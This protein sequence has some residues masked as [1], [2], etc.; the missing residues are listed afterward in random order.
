M[1]ERSY[2]AQQFVD[3]QIGHAMARA[4][5]R[6]DHPIRRQLDMEAEI[7]GTRDVVVRA[8]GESLDARITE[9]KR[10]PKFAASLP[11]TARVAKNDMKELTK[12]FDQIAAGT[13]VVE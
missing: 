5:L 6:T 10:D 8:K 9:L 4:G 2:V 1:T 11:Q 7:T 3:N 12:H 13:T